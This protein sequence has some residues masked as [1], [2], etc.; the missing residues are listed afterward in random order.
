MDWVPTLPGIRQSGRVSRPRHRGA[1]SQNTRYRRGV[2]CD[3]TARHA[4]P[5][6]RHAF[7]VRRRA[8]CRPREGQRRCL[9]MRRVELARIAETAYPASRSVIRDPHRTRLSDEA[10]EDLLGD[11]FPGAAPEDVEDFMRDLQRFGKLAAPVAQRALPGALQGA[12][13]G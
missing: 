3:G 6:R 8:G 1:G 12:T 7:R 13:L 4:W 10:I 2:P 9:S 11:L 5:A